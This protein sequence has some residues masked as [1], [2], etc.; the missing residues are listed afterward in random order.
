M[1]Y[2][3]DIITFCYNEMIILPWVVDYW[4]RI[5]RHVYVFDDGSTD[6]SKEFLDKLDF[7]TVIDMSFLTENKLNDRVLIWAKNNLFKMLHSD[8]SIICD[9]DECLYFSDLQHTL[10]LLRVSEYKGI[11]PFYCNMI[12]EHV[13]E[14]KEGIIIN[15]LFY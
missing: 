14:Y 6:G 4:R 12:C 5:A 8:F 1:K 2:T 3:V 15:N 11:R 9:M 13:P 7:V 10:D